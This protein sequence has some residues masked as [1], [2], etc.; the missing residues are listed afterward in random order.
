MSRLPTCEACGLEHEPAT[1]PYC[2]F[3]REKVTGKLATLTAENAR[4]RNELEN[5]RAGF[6]NETARRTDAVMWIADALVSMPVRLR[7]KGQAIIDQHTE[8]LK[9]LEA[10]R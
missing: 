10:G 6:G 1:P 4:L 8:E 3:E 9:A 7:D 5:W 2:T